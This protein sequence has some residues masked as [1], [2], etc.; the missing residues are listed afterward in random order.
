MTIS[1]KRFRNYE[2]AFLPWN[3]DIY[4]REMDKGEE[5]YAKTKIILGAREESQGVK[6]PIYYAI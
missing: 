4:E 1:G 5:R 2:Q 3:V 6:L